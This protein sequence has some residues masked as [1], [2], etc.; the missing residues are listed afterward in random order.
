MRLS[1]TYW[2][3]RLTLQQNDFSS[4]SHASVVLY[5]DH[6]S[7]YRFKSIPAPIRPSQGLHNTYQGF[8]KAP[9]QVRY[10]PG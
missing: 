10:L 7:V 5:T 6:L 1:C 3:P 8:H 9:E 2:I 4:R